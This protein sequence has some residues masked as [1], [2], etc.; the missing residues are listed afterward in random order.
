MAEV[1]ETQLPGIGARYDFTTAAGDQVGVLALRSGRREVVLYDRGD[2]D[3]ACATIHLDPEDARTLSETLGATQISESLLGIAQIEGITLDWVPVD[4]ASAA[5]DQ[6]I[7]DIQMRTRTGTSIV[8]IIRDEGH[9]TL[10][11]PGPEQRIEPGDVV[12]VVG[13]PEGIHKATLLLRG[14]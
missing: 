3:R 6:T 11:A 5:A 2:P 12:V 14:R 8:A 9:E 1:R 4:E 7:A 13:T 10:P